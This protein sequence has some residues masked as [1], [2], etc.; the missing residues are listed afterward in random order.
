MGK[1]SVIAIAILARFQ[2]AQGAVS[3]IPA[4]QEVTGNVPQ[5]AVSV[6]PATFGTIFLTVLGRLGDSRNFTEVSARATSN[7][8][9]TM[10]D[11]E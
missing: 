2:G 7:A 10:H 4:P 1:H 3:V 8:L 11:L 9:I 5:P 6:T